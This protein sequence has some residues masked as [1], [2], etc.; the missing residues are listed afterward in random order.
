[1]KHWNRIYLG[2]LAAL[3]VAALTFAAWVISATGIFLI[4]LC[5]G[6]RNAQITALFIFLIWGF[7]T[8]SKRRKINNRISNPYHNGKR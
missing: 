5:H 3:A 6:D 2:T 7:G 1:M 8:E 4:Q